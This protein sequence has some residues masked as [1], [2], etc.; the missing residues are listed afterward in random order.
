[1]AVARLKSRNLQVKQSPAESINSRNNSP[2]IALATWNVR[3]LRPGTEDDLLEVDDTRKT[4]IINDELK[5]LNI[6]VA[7]L[8]E[9]RLPE[10]GRLREADY[11][12]FWRGRAQD[13][14][15]QHGVGFAV[16]N[17]L[18]SHIIEPSGGN[19]RMLRITLLTDQ[20][21]I[22]LFSLYAPTLAADAG[23]KDAFYEE[24]DGELATVP[25]PEE[26]VL[27]GDFNARVGSD[28]QAWPDCLGPYGV[29]KINENGQRLLELCTYR[30]LSVTNT[31]FKSKMRHRVTWRHPR[32]KH[33]HQLDM[34]IAKRSSI[35]TFIHSRS[36]H[37][38]DCD[39]DHA[40]VRAKLR[41]KFRK[42]PQ[43]GTSR[44]KVPDV[45][46][47]QF[48]ETRQELSHRLLESL[49]T[50]DMGSDIESVWKKLR[51]NIVD[52]SMETL[53]R[54][55]RPKNDW[56]E[57]NLAIMQPLIETKREA[58][59][60]HKKEPTVLNQVRLREAKEEVRN[61]ARSCANEYWNVLCRQIQLD[62]D[63][64]NVQGMY[65]GMRRAFGPSIVKSAPLKSKEGLVL[66]GRQKQMERWVEHYLDIYSSAFI[67]QQQTL[68]EVPQSPILDQLDLP[69]TTEEL[70]SAIE[71]ATIGK[72]PGQDAISA[73]VLKHCKT[74]L[75]RP[76]YDLLLLCW[77]AGNVPQDFKDSKIVTIYKNKGD[78]S[79]CDNY[80]GISLLSVVGKIFAKV[81][82]G[83]LQTLAEVVLPESQCGFRA[84]RSTIDMIFTLAQLQ[85]KSREQRR[86]LYIAFVDLTKA[87]DLVGRDGLYAVLQKVGCPQ[88]LLNL[89][90]SFHDG[91]RG[92]VQ[93]DGSLSDSFPVNSGVKQG[94]VLAPTLFGIYFSVVL[95]HAFRNSTDG[96]Y[97]H[98]RSDGNL[99]NLS[100]LKA[101]TRIRKVLVRELLYADDAALVSHSESELQ[102]MVDA[103]ADSCSRFGLTISRTKTE[104][105]GQGVSSEPV[106]SI[107]HHNIKTV[108]NFTYLGSTVT[109]TASL[110]TELNRRIGKASGAMV[111]LSKRVWGN[112][113]LR[114][115]TK[116]TVYRACVVSTL[117]YG[118]EAWATYAKEE[119]K[120]SSFHLR[121]LRRIMNIHWYDKVT[122][123]EV[124]QRAGIGSIYS[125][126]MQ[127]RM[128]WLGHVRR[129]EDGRIPKDVMYGELAE[130]TR[131]IGRPRLRFKDVCKRDLKAAH[132]DVNTWESLAEDRTGWRRAT[133]LGAATADIARAQNA[134]ERRSRRHLRN[135]NN[136]ATENEAAFICEHCGRNCNSRIGLF[137]HRR[138][139]RLQVVSEGTPSTSWSQD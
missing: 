51:D 116:I 93:F 114:A 28:N 66:S 10:E 115:D 68:D 125:L 128:R 14:A 76:L 27:L 38:A 85:E 124:L 49:Q 94:C 62:A 97:L 111:R 83:R 41:V 87:F 59:L 95:N 104:V 137:S 107:E 127:R 45:K 5:R 75:L 129:M 121:C 131:S 22:H 72:S 103:L 37:S 47:L 108:D 19:E 3:T 53:G 120:L 21:N 73:D 126:L 39:T 135:N 8:Q 56:F 17:R 11:T 25:A 60:R 48:P 133:F 110:E 16:R 7:A 119:R 123:S 54:S 35:G 12:F 36:Y 24:L 112:D 82:L 55:K 113:K 63:S 138:A 74:V 78:R 81:V 98:T 96:V 9:T 117:L 29:G 58:F 139:C 61:A 70:V 100:R 2:V 34:I 88:R 1:M 33:W 99:F 122:N 101:K 57:E 106:I 52:T 64:G 42:P 130:G 102:R 79:L 4:A 32:S 23:V 69:P 44:S 18:L 65:Q 20:G 134:A 15:R 40:L 77:D 50:T 136:N 6:D 71:A 91:M 30:G 80:R 67:L 13:E 46:K 105:L 118:S 31:F 109:N 89:V 90:K 132:I 26:I 84:G 43:G 86:P 92:S